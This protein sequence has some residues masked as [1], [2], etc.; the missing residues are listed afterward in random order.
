MLGNFRLK[1]R[2]DDDGERQSL[3]VGSAMP[4]SSGIVA[5]RKQQRSALQNSY[6]IVKEVPFIETVPNMGAFKQHVNR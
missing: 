1:I 5:P 2:N 3:D 6:K 4:P